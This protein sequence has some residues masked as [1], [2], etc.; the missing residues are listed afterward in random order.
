M[1]IYIASDHGGFKLKE[2]LVASLGKNHVVNDLGPFKLNENDDY[3]DYVLLLTKEVLNEKRL[4]ILICRSGQ[5]T[6]IAANKVKGIRAVTGFSKKMIK[7]TRNDNNAN[8]LCLPADYL[9]VR[10]AKEIAELFLTTK[11]SKARRHVRRL[12]K[13]RKMEK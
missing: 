3:P 11:F 12:N 7:S 10:E 4:G 2:K 9:G 8:V 5:G 1:K 6:C 13:I